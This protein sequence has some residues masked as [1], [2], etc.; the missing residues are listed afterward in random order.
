V[1]GILI[2]LQLNNWNQQRK[3]R[4]EELK[5]LIQLKSDLME[6]KKEI[7]RA[8][9]EN[10]RIIGNFNELITNLQQTKTY[11][12]NLDSAFGEI[13]LWAAP[14]ISNS[15]Y[16]TLKSKGLDMISNDKLRNAI[17]VYFNTDI[18]ILL[19][20]WG[21]WEWNIN[22]QVVLPWYSKNCRY[23]SHILAKPN[24]YNNLVAN[25]DELLNILSLLIRSHNYGIEKCYALEHKM[26]HL[27]MLIDTELNKSRFKTEKNN[28]DSIS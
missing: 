8:N 26:D 3:E 21:K 16:E 10:S 24:D 19:N 23:Y 18:P 15:T 22:Q 4:I 6:S 14:Y 11:T 25:P 5:I 28:A 9:K 2:A 27:I 20:D 7:H 12:S 13:P 17:S 1:I